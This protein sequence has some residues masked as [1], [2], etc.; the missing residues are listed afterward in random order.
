MD[1]LALNDVLAA[2]KEPLF[3][4][5]QAKR[6]FYAEFLKSWRDVSTYPEILRQALEREIP[7]DVLSEEKNIQSQDASTVKKL[8]SCADGSI[9]ESVLMRHEDGR[10]TV[11]LSCQV[12]CPMGCVFCA[13][14]AMGFKRNLTLHEIAEQTIWFSR[15][16]KEQEAKVTNVVFMGMGE[17]FNNYNEVLGAV[18]LLNDPSGF[19]L[20]ARHITISTSGIVPGILKFAKEPRQVNLAVSLHS[21][22]DET[23]SKLMPVNKVYPLSKLMSALAE[24]AKITNRK[25]FFEYLLIDGVNDDL[26]QA[27]ELVKLLSSNRRLYHVNLIK[28]HD[29]GKFKASDLK[30]HE[31]FRRVLREAGINTTERISFGEDIDAACGQLAL[32]SLK[33]SG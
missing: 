19:N 13:S 18:R 17:P 24:Y 27:Q 8:F 20:G 26:R 28:Y 10:N 5:A 9:I 30:C 2:K 22:I 6:S 3:R 11:C 1:T 23:R 12:G 31:E 4:L 21:A 15:L 33:K 16:L 7:W 29:T 32:K 14:G 25:I